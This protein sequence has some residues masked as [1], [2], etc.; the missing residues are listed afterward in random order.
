MPA[1]NKSKSRICNEEE[2]ERS[3]VEPVYLRSRGMRYKIEMRACVCMCFTMQV[4]AMH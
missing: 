3:Q 2:N 1:R 4:K